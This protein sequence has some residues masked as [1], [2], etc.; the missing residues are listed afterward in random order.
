M[1]KRNLLFFPGCFLLCIPVILQAQEKEIPETT[2]YRVETFGSTATGNHTPFWMVSNRY[3]VTPLEA[4]NGYLEAGVFHNSSFGKGFRWSAGLEMVGASPRYKKLYLQQVYI[5]L[6][7]KCLQLSVGSREKYHSLWDQNLSSGD[8]VESAN[9]RPI[10]EINLSLPR[11]VT[12]PFTRGWLH[13]KGDFAVGRSFDTD[14]LRYFSKA[15]EA[16]HRNI[17][18]HHK[19][20][21]IKIEDKSGNSPVSFTTGIRHWAMWGGTHPI[22]GKQPQSLGDFIRVV[23]GDKGGAGASASDQVNALGSHHGTFDFKLSYRK[24]GGEIHAYYQHFFRDNSGIEFKNGTDGLWGIE[25]RS[26]HFPWLNKLV[27]EYIDTRNQ[28]GPLHFI[29]FDHKVHPG[30]GGGNDNYYNNPEYITGLSYF[31]RALGNP[32]LLS[33]EYNE[34]GVL[35]FYSNWIQNWHLG[36]EGRIIRNVSYRLLLTQMNSWGKLEAPFLHKK[37]ATSIL[38]DINYQPN[39][40]KGWSFRGSYARDKGELLGN[41]TGFSLSISKQG[42]LK[43]W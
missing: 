40:T 12:L 21:L 1:K 20:L 5:G 16:Y 27:V 14:Y 34:N 33:P 29:S 36:A 7:Y 26:R 25:L 42:L 32:L 13:V 37:R 19:S 2:S 18:W 41:S 6:Y 15:G 28:S 39:P 24:E 3:G 35:G 10:P 30:R 17:L 9:A 43:E 22:L 8:L 11:Y 38:I 23:L 31:N 4:G